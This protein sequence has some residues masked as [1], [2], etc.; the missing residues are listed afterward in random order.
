[1]LLNL[2]G[3]AGLAALA[4]GLVDFNNVP[5]HA[6][7]T[8]GDVRQGAVSQTTGAEAMKRL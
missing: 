3:D 1:M 8:S 6:L 7:M 5:H 2:G 4:P